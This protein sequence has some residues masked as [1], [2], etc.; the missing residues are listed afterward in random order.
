MHTL[1]VALL[2]AVVVTATASAQADTD[3]RDSSGAGWV[4]I[5]GGL[6]HS[7]HF[8]VDDRWLADRFEPE[9]GSSATA[10]G[11]GPVIGLDAAHSLGEGIWLLPS[12]SYAR[13][14][15]SRQRSGSGLHAIELYPVS[16]P[17][18]AAADTA[19]QRVPLY[20]YSEVQYHAIRASALFGV[21]L[22]ESD[23]VALGIALGPASSLLLD[24]G[25]EERLE[26]QPSVRGRFANAEG[27][28]VERQTELIL[29][30]DRIP[31][32]NRFRIGMLG[33]VFSRYDLAE[34]L[35]LTGSVLVDV[36]LTGVEENGSHWRAIAIETLV[37][38]RLRL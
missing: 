9:D 32:A 15:A 6:A 8:N 17:D 29:F 2:A 18:T 21:E 3:R 25:I 10:T 34:R 27:Y 24:P 31:G 4:G 20:L 37:G 28:P 12:I 11:I 14:E 35:T 22:V 36:P 5:H 13:W 33:G 30:D 19:R 26:L 7:I 16:D 38:L 23:Q 1:L